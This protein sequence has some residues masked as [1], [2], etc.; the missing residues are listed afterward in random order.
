[1]KPTGFA[2]TRS[3]IRLAG[4]LFAMTVTLAVVSV[5]T[6]QLHVERFG[7]GAPLVQLDRVTVTAERPASERALAA[8]PAAWRAN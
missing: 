7:E 1:M 2:Q 8:A 6:E 5:L 3:T 4:A